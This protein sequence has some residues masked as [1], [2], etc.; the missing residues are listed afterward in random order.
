MRPARSGYLLRA[1]T[2]RKKSANFCCR[3]D[4]TYAWRTILK[5]I[6]RVKSRP[7]ILRNCPEELLLFLGFIVFMVALG[8]WWGAYHLGFD[9]GI[10]L[11]KAALV[12]NG[13]SLYTEIWSDQPP[14]LTFILSQVHQL[15][16]FSIAAAR[17]IVLLFAAV[18]VVS[19]YRIVCR[20]EGRRCALACVALLLSSGLFLGLAV[21]VK[22]GLPAIAL[23]VIALDVVTGGSGPCSRPRLVSGGLVFGLAILTKMFVVL[24]LPTL[25]LAIWI[26]AGRH[27]SEQSR[28]YQG[29]EDILI[30]TAAIV[31]VLALVFFAAGMDQMGQLIGPHIS[32]N[33]IDEFANVG[34]FAVVL[35]FLYQHSAAALLVGSVGVL[36]AFIRPPGSRLLPL[37]WLILATIVLSYHR[38]LWGH[39]LLLILV[40]LC[41][42]GGVA[43]GSV[44]SSAGVLRPDGM[45]RSGKL[46]RYPMLIY[47]LPFIA[48]LVVVVQAIQSTGE[49]HTHFQRPWTLTEELYQARYEFFSAVGDRVVT[50]RPIDAYHA[51]KLVPPELAVWSKKRRLTG[52]LTDEEI[53][54]VIGSNP[55]TQVSLGRFRYKQGFIEEIGKMLRMTSKNFKGAKAPAVYHFAPDIA[56]S[57][58]SNELN[59]VGIQ[60]MGLMSSLGM[61]GIGGVWNSRENLHYDRIMSKEAHDT[62]AIVARPPG[63]VQELGS[64]LLGAWRRTSQKLFLLEALQLGQALACAQSESGGW[65]KSTVVKRIPCSVERKK[66]KDRKL[67]FDDGT[68]SSA[69][70]FA[71]DLKE[72]L[73]E[74]DAVVPWWLSEMIDNAYGFILQSQDQSGGWPQS[75]GASGYKSHITL[76][77]DAM[78]GLMRVLIDSYERSGNSDHLEA[79]RRAGNYLLRVQGPDDQ[80]AFAQQYSSDE[81]PA[82]ARKFE[83]AAYAS[84]ETAFAINALIDL[85][86]VTGDESYRDAASRASSWLERSEV[87]PGQWAR[88]YET[89]SNAVIFADRAGAIHRR[90]EDL[91]VAEQASYDWIGGRD[92]FPDIG[93]ALDRTELLE[94]GAG[95][96]HRYDENLEKSALLPY[97]PTA[98]AELTTRI[99]GSSLEPLV[100]SREIVE[101]CASILALEH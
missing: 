36:L 90:L 68:V 99:P 81:L 62:G 98:R 8:G 6:G 74:V 84:L 46:G 18:L 2:T 72:E 88:F 97:V 93:M 13:H 87:G 80:A 70:Y 51:G 53:L 57:T 83:P 61:T 79:A 47:P 33:D 63:S 49:A 66:P 15:F 67:T 85:Y 52:N 55:D 96:V 82:P 24:I 35:K 32:A 22:I 34:G 100:S 29:P 60:I 37:V 42:L 3:A 28:S 77:D 25:L 12:A 39:H 11:Q 40:P 54:T 30:F 44:F 91:P 21:S 7:G 26:R 10:N 75:P 14:L 9:E 76:N 5:F 27:R 38:P 56:I 94:G 4:C 17:T 69:L 95:P 48:I 64:C 59:P 89:G 58:T 20:F 78:T 43:L 71:L 19:L 50:D 16:P 23:A 1:F 41:W 73:I 65:A 92:R 101:T 31:S 86:L 45:V